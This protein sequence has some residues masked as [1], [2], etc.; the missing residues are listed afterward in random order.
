M[1]ICLTF[2]LAFTLIPA[3]TCTAPSLFELRGAIQPPSAAS[4]TLHSSVSPFTKSLLAGPDGR[5]RLREIPAG[6]YTLSVF[7]PG[8]GELRR[9]IEIGPGTAGQRNL[10]SVTL[11]LETAAL[12]AAEGG[13]HT[14]S[15]A[16]LAVSDS[17][18]RDYAKAQKDLA[19]PDIPRAIEHLKSAVRKSPGF[20]AAWNNLGTIA[21]QTRN[22]S[23]AETYFREALRH[24]ASSFP[25]LVNLGGVLLTLGKLDEAWKYNL[26]AVLSRPGDALANSQL[27]MTYFALNN[28]SLA[29][30]HLAQ[31]KRI[32]PVHF[33]FPQLTLAEIYS[34]M[35]KESAAIAELEEFLRYHPDAANA[36]RVRELLKLLRQ[37][38]QQTLP[39]GTRPP[40]PRGHQ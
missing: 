32:D 22:Y 28:F 24:D 4:V 9:T 31:A 27:G 18:R 40:V 38:H 37:P 35:G 34:R 19:K 5:F 11:S 15:I 25:P 12:T 14:V 29:I 36:G 6:I 17:A 33:S 13:G 23:E 1:G 39:E 3:G 7:A 16:E 30:K 2:V 20:T 8:K 10:I 26:Y 21:Y